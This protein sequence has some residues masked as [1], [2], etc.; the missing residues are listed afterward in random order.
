MELRDII[1]TPLLLVIIGIT[2]I[3]VRP[4]FTDIVNRK[5][6]LPALWAKIIGALALGFI[7]Q[8]YY[9][10]GDT[11]AYHTHGSRVLWEAFIDSPF[12]GIRIAFSNGKYGP[13][14]WESAEQIWLWRDPKSFII[15]RLAFFLDILTF[16]TYSGTAILFSIIAFIGG[17]MLFLTFYRMYPTMHRW[18]A[19]SCLFIPSIVFWGSGILKDTITLAFL[20]MGTFAFY[21]IFVQ[22]RFSVFSG[23]LLIISF[24]VIFSI[25]KYILIS[26]FAAAMIWF[27][28]NDVGKVKN[29][30]LR[31]MVLPVALSL[32]LI[33]GYVAINKV[34]EDDPRYALDKIATTAKVTAN[35]IRYGWGARFG[36]GSGY[37]LGELDGTL[38]GMVQL[39]PQAI[40]VSLF[41]PY[42]WEAKNALMLLTSLEG[43]ITFL[44][45]CYVLLHARLKI[46]EYIK[47]PPVVF[48]LVFS[49][50]FAFGVGVSTFNFGTLARYKIPLLPY[51]F[52]MLGILYY[53]S[54]SDK[55]SDSVDVTE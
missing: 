38:S 32:C 1:V 49:L 5:Y 35:D 51:Y 10:G 53:Y 54:K 48:C 18:L 52:A 43:L 27:F 19:I 6:F 28:S 41:R 3:I 8:F 26:F 44:L 37:T 22:K 42:I 4:L 33:L 50:I 2:A 21:T 47:K 46:I 16:S 9:S 17:W 12:E 39:A 7:Y 30:T 23:I 36:D 11:F 34:V 40:N 29:P 31:F 45:T 15:I 13:G 25:K 24:V 55:K 20:G 14:L